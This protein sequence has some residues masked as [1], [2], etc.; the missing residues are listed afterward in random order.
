MVRDTTANSGPPTGST[1]TSAP[2]ALGQLEQALAQ[3][4]PAMVDGLVGAP[5][6]GRGQAL[7]ARG[8]GDDPGAQ[9]LAQL[10]GGQADTA[11]GA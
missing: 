8:H 2:A 1:T 11:A 6:Q 10:D 7:V 9:Q 5:G 4:L 3:V